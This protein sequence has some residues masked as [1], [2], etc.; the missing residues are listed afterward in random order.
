[1]KVFVYEHFCASRL[2]PDSPTSLLEEGRSML[3]AV[4]SELIAQPDVFATTFL[5]AGHPELPVA[6]RTTFLPT[7]SNL[8]RAIAAQAASADAFVVIAPEMGGVACEVAG[9]VEEAGGSLLGVNARAIALFSDKL[10]TYQA[11]PELSIPTWEWSASPQS[12]QVVLKPRDGVGALFTVAGPGSGLGR[13]ERRVREAGF[14]GETVLQP[15]WP[16]LPASVA[17]L[18]RGTGPAVLLPAVEQIIRLERDAVEQDLSWFHYEGGA[19]PLGGDLGRRARSLAGAFASKLDPFVGYLGIDLILGR[20]SDGTLDRIVDVNP[21]I[22]TSFVGYRRMFPGR[23]GRLLL[24]LDPERTDPLADGS[25][26][27]RFWPDGR[28]ETAR[29]SH[30][31]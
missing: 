7:P 10:A 24:G 22:T 11:F 26:A 14:A 13:M 1:M 6:P 21:R 15:H 31:K 17:A 30:E 27:F 12:D 4:L 16:G 29:S 8:C 19:L 23:I 3:T 2:V 18:G 20:D 9:W 5:G 25:N 28:V